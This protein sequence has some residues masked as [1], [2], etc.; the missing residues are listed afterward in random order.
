MMVLLIVTKYEK[1]SNNGHFTTGKVGNLI[2]YFGGAP[3]GSEL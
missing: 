1:D 2:S 3:P